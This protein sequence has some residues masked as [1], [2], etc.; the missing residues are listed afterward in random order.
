[1][2]VYIVHSAFRQ[3]KLIIFRVFYKKIYVVFNEAT[4][5]D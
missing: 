5:H 3:F 2:Q 4:K 1:M